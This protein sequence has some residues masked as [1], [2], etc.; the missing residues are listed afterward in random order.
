MHLLPPTTSSRRTARSLAV[1]LAALAS[2][3]AL[4]FAG[5]RAEGE[6]SKL[7]GAGGASEP[8]AHEWRLV[9]SKFWQI[10][11]PAGEAP[12]V[13]DAR[14][15]NR[16]HCPEGMVEVQGK[17]RVTENGDGLQQS[18]CKNWI[19]RKFPERCAEFDRDKWHEITAKLPTRDMHFCIDRFEYPNRKGEYPYV[20]MDW[21]EAG[22]VCKGQG[23][24]LCSEDEWTFACEGEE[25]LPYPYGYVRDVEACITDKP[26]RPFQGSWAVFGRGSEPTKRELDR[27]WQGLPS[28]A[29]PK[30]RSP[31]GVYDMVGNVDEWTRSTK[32]GRQSI[33]KGGYWGP[34]RTRC[35]PTPRA[36]G[37]THVF[38]QEGV[39]CCQNAP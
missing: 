1:A 7:P 32:P 6:P 14:E 17:M 15:G 19:S 8:L 22:A 27:L 34:V 39:R 31:F 20:L 18:T 28:G 25:A 23:K 33:L 30:C 3:A 16:G 4:V 26:W 11:S 9:D 29:Q 37:E 21:H 36:H 24:R 5:G 12:S 2:A 10:V 13:T 35:R 38:Y